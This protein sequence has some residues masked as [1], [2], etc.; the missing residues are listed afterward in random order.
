MLVALLDGTWQGDCHGHFTACRVGA[1]L[2]P[3]GQELGMPVDSTS[4]R[5]GCPRVFVSASVGSLP[6]ECQQGDC[7]FDVH[8]YAWV[9]SAA[10]GDPPSDH[11]NLTCKLQIAGLGSLDFGAE[12]LMAANLPAARLKQMQTVVTA[13]KLAKNQLATAMKTIMEL[14]SR[15]SREADGRLAAETVAENRERLAIAQVG[16]LY[17]VSAARSIR[18]I[19]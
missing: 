19:H 13:T 18:R 4:I 7:V 16:I 14:K 3:D 12:G 6:S 9:S 1:G 8:E 17:S 5:F 2:H 10:D 15:T 11:E